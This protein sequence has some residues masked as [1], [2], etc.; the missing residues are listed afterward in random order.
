MLAISNLSKQLLR[1]E[2]LS[3]HVGEDIA[4]TMIPYTNQYNESDEETVDPEDW[5][6]VMMLHGSKS[7]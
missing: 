5:T 3:K 1:E 6:L 7:K 4:V 2:E